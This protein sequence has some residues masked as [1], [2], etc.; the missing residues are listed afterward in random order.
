MIFLSFRAIILLFIELLLETFGCLH[1][2]SAIQL[3]LP[4]FA[5]K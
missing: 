5:T 2:D 3:C 4:L 1:K